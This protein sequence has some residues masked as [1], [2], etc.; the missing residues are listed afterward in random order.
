VS[1]FSVKFFVFK[2]IRFIATVLMVTFF[3]TFALSLVPGSPAD[4]MAGVGATQAQ[5][6]AINKEYGFNEN[7]FV[8]YWHWLTA[9]LHGDLSRSFFTKQTVTSSLATR[10]PVTAE[11]AILAT[12]VAVVVALLFAT[13]AARNPGGRIDTALRPLT[14]AQISIPS[15]VVALLLTYIFAV[16][17]RW[18]PLLGWTPLTES[19]WGNIKCVIMPVLAI[20]LAPAAGLTV[21]LRAD[22]IQT[23]Q[24]DYIA[25]ARA[26]GHSTTAIIWKHALKPSSFSLITL[27]S[28]QLAALLG[29]TVIVESIFLLPGMGALL[30]SSINQK[31]Y[32][33]VT[34]LVAFIA[35]VFL[36]VN[37]LV[38]ILY[39]FLDPRIRTAGVTAR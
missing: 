32:P 20:A 12:L 13:T 14:Y 21:V 9:A 36:T 27:S 33:V 35:V 8:R 25:L 28:L 22:L 19:V 23:L 30:L 1:G 7:V 11:L 3:A 16:Q 15:F 6:D 34:G 38:D 26:K 18:L 29:G 31:D 4:E 10:L 2:F 37:F 17:L 24:Q 5:I 39:G